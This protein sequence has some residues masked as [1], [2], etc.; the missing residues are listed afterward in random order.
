MQLRAALR[1]SGKACP[2][3]VAGMGCALRRTAAD[4]YSMKS[5]AFMDAAANSM[6]P[7]CAY[8]VWL[9]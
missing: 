9:G 6:W 2:N 3:W 7:M 8:T 1:V 5:L 4:S